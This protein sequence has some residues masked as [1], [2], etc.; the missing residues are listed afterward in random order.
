MRQFTEHIFASTEITYL[1]VMIFG[2]NPASAR[3]LE[4][5]GFA[6]CGT[7][8]SAAIKNGKIIDLLIYEKLKP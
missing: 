1:H 7:M 2:N 3:V 5:V 6:H 4:K 8:H